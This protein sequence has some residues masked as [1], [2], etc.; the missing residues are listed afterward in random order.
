MD[1]VKNQAAIAKFMDRI[2]Y[3]FKD[4][5]S[6]ELKE[7]YTK[8]YDRLVTCQNIPIEQLVPEI[9][10]IKLVAHAAK[11]ENSPNTHLVFGKNMRY[12]AK[13]K[14]C[15][16]LSVGPEENILLLGTS[17]PEEI[18]LAKIDPEKL[19]KLKEITVYSE[20]EPTK[21][22]YNKPKLTK[23]EI[24]SQ[25]PEDLLP[26]VYAYELDCSDLQDFNMVLKHY[27]YNV[28]LYGSIAE[29]DED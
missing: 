2:N 7:K 15:E 9:Q 17:V 22:G 23:R 27:G 5:L 11:T 13:S 29:Q 4:T 26:Q 20:G 16:P 14:W 1:S 18:S 19:C 12:Y 8:I 28:V 6:A 25:I 21:L 10:R 24:V 3:F